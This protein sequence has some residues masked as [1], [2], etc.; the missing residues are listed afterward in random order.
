MNRLVSNEPEL[1]FDDVL[2]IPQFSTITTRDEISIGTCVPG[3]DFNLSLDLPVVISNMDTVTGTKMI[4]QMDLRGGMAI[5]HRY[6]TLEDIDR[7]IT[8]QD[9]C[10]YPISVGSVYSTEEKAKIDYLLNHKT[11]C[12]D[13]VLCVD[14]S[15]GFSGHMVDTLDYIRKNQKNPLFLI[16]GN[17]SEPLAAK[18]LRAHGADMIKV[19]IGPGSVCTT[20][21][22]TG[23]GRPQLSAIQACSEYG[24][25]LA[26]GG[27]RTPGDIAKAIAMADSLEYRPL[28]PG[29][30]QAVAERTYL[31]R[32]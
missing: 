13:L 21:I 17:V 27:L 31:G 15:N 28:H 9:L 23:V 14:M 25:V 10:Y 18:L 26:D 6:S 3:K 8:E 16:A 2:I 24:P 5:L 29:M 30:G 22:Q 20:R 12:D 7:F 4:R 1:T 11:P 19:G 32:S